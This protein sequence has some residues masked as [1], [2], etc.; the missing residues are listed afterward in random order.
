MIPGPYEV[1]SGGEDPVVR[2][3]GATMPELFE[4]AAFAMFAVGYDLSDVAPT[5]ARPISTG[6]HGTGELLLAW[7]REILGM[8]RIEGI[9]PSFFMVDR[10]DDGVVQG[11]ASGL[12]IAD[13]PPAGRP[14][15]DIAT[16]HP[17]FVQIPDGWWVEL[18]FATEPPLRA[19]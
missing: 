18:R 14:V 6:G 4:N 10:L 7:L 17:E 16:R 13:V 11:S 19:I 5:Y 9:V 15:T 12:Y 3:Y 2:V 1:L 8:V